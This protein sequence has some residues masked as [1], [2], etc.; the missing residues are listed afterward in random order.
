MASESVERQTPEKFDCSPQ[1]AQ[2]SKA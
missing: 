2:I 1:M